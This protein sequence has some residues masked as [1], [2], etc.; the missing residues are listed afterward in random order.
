VCGYLLLT[1]RNACWM[2]PPP[3]NLVTTGLEFYTH[4]TSSP[5]DGA[6]HTLSIPASIA[7]QFL[8]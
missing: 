3:F 5:V 6:L 7:D 4:G 8:R 1:E 2:L